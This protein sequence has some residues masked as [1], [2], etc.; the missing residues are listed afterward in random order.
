MTLTLLVCLNFVALHA[1]PGDPLTV[2][3]GDA[4]LVFPDEALRARLA[5]LHGLDGSLGERFLRYV[6]RLARGDLGWSLSHA[7]P[8]RDLVIQML[9]WTLAL[10]AC[11]SVL[12][13]VLGL[14]GGVEAALRH[15]SRENP[16]ILATLAFLDSIPPFVKAIL[17][18][19][20]FGLWL[21]V[22]PT[23]GALAP[24]SDTTGL[25]RALE[26]AHHAVAPV[27]TLA[28][29]ETSKLLLFARGTTLALLSRPFLTVAVAK[30]V[31]PWR[32]RRAYLAPNA[33]AAV[34]ARTAALMSGM[35]AGA[36]FVETVFAYPGIGR[37]AVEAIA[38]RDL[39]LAQGL[40]LVLGA[41]I[42][43]LNLVAD[44]IVLRLDARG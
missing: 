21:E 18:L 40:F 30:G 11:A 26:L 25:A 33:L 15:G 12:A 8:V 23:A 3:L 28:V 6:G 35:M 22:V 43:T 5:D 17:I 29:H 36:V 1:L 16:W 31:G 32:L 34:V 10:V 14:G 20:V 13:F 39:P 19:F 41:V 2:L 24:F 42:L 4:T 9:P 27:A 7:A 38:V 37:L 44:L